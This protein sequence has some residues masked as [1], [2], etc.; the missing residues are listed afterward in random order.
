MWVR[1]FD[2]KYV[3]WVETFDDKYVEWFGAFDDEYVEWEFQLL[4]M[5][6]GDWTGQAY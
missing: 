2:D 3:E 1:A 6:R 5:N 4:M